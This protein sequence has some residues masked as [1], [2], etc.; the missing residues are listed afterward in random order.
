MRWD[1]VRY[2]LALKEHRTL[3]KCSAVL[4]VSEATVIRQIQALENSL[5]ATLF[6]RTRQG[7]NLTVAGERVLQKAK[8]MEDVAD[9]LKQVVKGVDG[10]I[11]GNVTIATTEMASEYLIG[12]AL[13][14]F[15]EKFPNIRLSISVTPEHQNLV[16][17]EAWVALRFR[18]PE[19]GP[20]VM[21]KIGSVDWGFYASESVLQKLD[22]SKP[23]SGTE[24]YIDWAP[25]VDSITVATV[26]RKAFKHGH[27]PVAL[28][29]LHSHLVAAKK[30]IGIAHLPCLVGEADP[31]LHKIERPGSSCSLDAWLVQPQ[32]FR[33]LARVQT[34]TQFIKALK[35]SSVCADTDPIH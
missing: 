11:A 23:L 28:S 4:N 30:G 33:Q 31:M 18:R 26:L 3:A 17:H 25:P 2:F 24:P 15:S 22:G 13:L 6:V 7:H 1:G 10:D 21:Q 16:H 29:T 14:D 19:K 32:Q 27:S 12:P 5:N 34:V 20:Y 8:L 9:E 35:A